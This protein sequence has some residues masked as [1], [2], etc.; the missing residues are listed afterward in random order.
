MRY[1]RGCAILPRT[2]CFNRL[3]EKGV[4]VMLSAAKHLL[5]LI[6]NKQKQILR[7]RSG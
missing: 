2:L 7:S 1:L 4:S 5:F 3:A 6:E